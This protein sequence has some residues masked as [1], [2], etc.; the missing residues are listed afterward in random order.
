MISRDAL[1]NVYTRRRRARGKGDLFEK[2]RSDSDR[3]R[4]PIALAP[5]LHVTQSPAN[6]EW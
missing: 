2:E 5:N 4:V 6:R 3:W 1:P